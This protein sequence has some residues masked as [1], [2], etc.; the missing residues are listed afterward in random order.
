MAQNTFDVTGGVLYVVCCFLEAGIF[1][2]HIVWRI[3]TRK[4]RKAA[5]AEGKTFDDVIAEHEARGEP[6]KW[7]D[8]KWRGGKA[9]TQ[10]A[11]EEAGYATEDKAHPSEPESPVAVGFPPG[12]AVSRTIDGRL[13]GEE[14]T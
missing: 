9:T 6:F 8:R 13:I 3:R 2:S 1:A 11:D 14:R 10:K 7:T 5:A 4:I 12:T